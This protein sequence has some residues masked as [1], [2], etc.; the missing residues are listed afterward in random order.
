[1]CQLKIRC[2]TTEEERKIDTEGQLV[3]SDITSSKFSFPA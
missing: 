3:L 2:F 1:M